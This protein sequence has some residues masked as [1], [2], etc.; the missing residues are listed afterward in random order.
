MRESTMINTSL[1]SS[2]SDTPCGCELYPLVIHGDRL[3]DIWMFLG[4][5]FHSTSTGFDKA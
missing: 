1:T 2:L 5:S 4:K 3:C